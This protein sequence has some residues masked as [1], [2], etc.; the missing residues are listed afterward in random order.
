METHDRGND[1][2]PLLFATFL[3]PILSPY[4]E[5]VADYLGSRVGLGSGLVEDAT[6]DQFA[7][8]EVDAGFVGAASYVGLVDR[9]TDPVET[10]AA[11]VVAEARYRGRPVCFSDVVVLADGPLKGFTDLRGRSLSY[12]GAD[13]GTGYAAILSRLGELGASEGYFG[14]VVEVRSHERS[15]GLVLAG[16]VDAAAMDSHVLAMAVRADPGLKDRLRVIDMLGPSPS[17]PV[18]AARRLPEAL[19]EEIRGLLT[20]MHRG[21]VGR[22]ALD[23]GLVERFVPVTDE[24]YDPIRAMMATARAAGA[25]THT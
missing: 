6:L 25:T 20:S 12:N 3:A 15:L 19:R 16:D 24:D 13:P 5:A 22:A 4:C 17:E 7:T 11:P 1:L 2:E 18:V 9:E 8:R 14:Q 23:L 10:L 21:P